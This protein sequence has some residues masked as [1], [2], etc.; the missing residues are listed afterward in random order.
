MWKKKNLIDFIINRCRSQIYT[1]GLLPSVLASSIKSL[2]II[3]SNKRLIKKPLENAIFFSKIVGLELPVSPIVPIILGDEN[4]ALNLSRYLKR[5][6]YIVGAIR[7]PTVPKGTSRLRLAF[8]SSHTK[9][10][11]K[12]L[13]NLIKN[14]L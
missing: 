2:E 10:Q 4:K 13:A 5:F 14:K 6:G 7:P 1:T 9:L 8:N 11:I 3:K 12:S